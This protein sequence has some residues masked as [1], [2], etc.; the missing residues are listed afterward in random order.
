[1]G[2]NVFI[3][4]TYYMPNI[5]CW[6]MDIYDLD[7]NP[8]LLGISLNT[9]VENLVKGKSTLFDGQAIRCISTDGNENNTPV[10]LGTTCFVLYYA[11]GEEVPPLYEDKMLG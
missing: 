9:G 1:M 6:L 10:S 8:I 4:E 11:K 5:K 7:E 2:E 3:L